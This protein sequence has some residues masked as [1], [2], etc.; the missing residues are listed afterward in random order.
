MNILQTELAKLEGK[1][2]G[3]KNGMK[4][5]LKVGGKEKS[6]AKPYYLECCK[7]GK[8]WAEGFEYGLDLAVRLLTK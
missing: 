6:I 2:Q 4:I 1:S 8:D 7:R 3:F 5:A